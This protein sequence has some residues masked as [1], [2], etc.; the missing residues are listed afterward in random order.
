VIKLNA[1]Q[2]GIPILKESLDDLCDMGAIIP[3]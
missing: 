3:K 1:K 2:R